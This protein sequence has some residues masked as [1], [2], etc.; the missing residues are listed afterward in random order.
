M[1]IGIH[2][3]VQDEIVVTQNMIVN[4]IVYVRQHRHS[5]MN[6]HNVQPTQRLQQDL[7]TQVLASS[8]NVQ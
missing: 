8:I 4:T 3:D 2:R 1:A 6:A 7:Q 5:R